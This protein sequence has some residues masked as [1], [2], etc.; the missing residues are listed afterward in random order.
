M[1]R[2]P[3]RL[4]VERY[5]CPKDVIANYRKAAAKMDDDDLVDQHTYFEKV[6]Q[7]YEN[8]VQGED[9]S[10]W[11]VRFYLKELHHEMKRRGL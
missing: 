3:V 8:V 7:R 4:R 9:S 5:R 6:V 10:V 2:T 1:I 11:P